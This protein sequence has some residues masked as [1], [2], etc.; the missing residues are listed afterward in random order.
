MIKGILD[1]KVFVRL[2]KKERAL[3]DDAR[4]EYSATM[5]RFIREEIILPW[6]EKGKGKR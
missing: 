3:L 4:K 1:D 5:S 2:T 6:L